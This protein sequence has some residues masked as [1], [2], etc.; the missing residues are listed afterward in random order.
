MSN[1][2]VKNL[3]KQFPG[4]ESLALDNVSFAVE[5][6]EII[7]LL[8]PS[9]CGKTT[10]LRCIAGLED[11]DQGEIWL[12]DRKITLNARHLV[13]PERRGMGM[14]FQSYS[15]WPHMTVGENIAIGL[16]AKGLNRSEV[17]SKV[18][19]VLEMVRLPG[20]ERRPATDLSGGQ[21]QRVALAR[22]LAL[23]PEVLLF[24]E[25]LSNLDANLREQMRFELRELLQRLGITSV[26]VTHDQTEAFVISD[27]VCVMQLGHL[28]QVGTPKEIY[29][30]PATRFVA[31]FIGSSNIL[32]GTV[33]ES[34]G[35]HT[36]VDIGGDRNVW[37]TGLAQRGAQVEV[38][39]RSEGVKLQPCNT[40]SRPENC[41]EAEV[42]QRV[43]LGSAYQ[44]SVLLGKQSLR[45]TTGLDTELEEGQHVWVVATPDNVLVLGTS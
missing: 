12:N 3:V 29:Q 26:Y 44:Y 4:N 37:A 35:Q 16:R 33:H 42:V 5:E 21:Q 45:I 25:P 34:N 24:D 40:S 43:Y 27:R 10:T 18:Q 6:G 1:L 41:V 7:A 11:P 19:E 9:G 15:I 28:V 14:V 36:L 17:E 32:E 2:L 38:S 23:E 8:G 20:L 22:S 31:E 39:I 30:R 13:P